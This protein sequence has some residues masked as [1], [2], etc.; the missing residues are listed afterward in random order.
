MARSP[1][2]SRARAASGWLAGCFGVWLVACGP[3]APPVADV[4]DLLPSAEV[5]PDASAPRAPDPEAKAREELAALV[6]GLEGCSFDAEA[7]MPPEEC[8]GWQRWEAAEPK[9]VERDEAKVAALLAHDAPLVRYG[10]ASALLAHGVRHITELPLAEAIVSQA[11]AEQHPGV[12]GLL[13]Q[14]VLKLDQ[15]SLAQRLRTLLL[16]HP[17]RELRAGLMA[18]GALLEGGSELL[19]ALFDKATDEDKALIVEGLWLGEEFFTCSVFARALKGSAFQAADRAAYGIAFGER[20]PKLVGAVLR[21]VMG[22]K[23]APRGSVVGSALGELCR[24]GAA[25]GGERILAANQARRLSARGEPEVRAGALQAVMRCDSRTGAHFMRGYLN[26]AEP[27][28]REAAARL[29]E[30]S[31]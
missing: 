11:E 27:L 20:C 4:P 19:A 17:N 9:L 28:V 15:P 16:S 2:R 13:A 3:N 7:L 26:D 21:W 29:L 8:P 14:L 5:P 22:V 25:R 6:R 10:A 12:G 18:R 31:P 23:E 30:A 1:R 24:T